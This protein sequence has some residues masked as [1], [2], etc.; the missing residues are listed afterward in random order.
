MEIMKV[1]K[2]HKTK[3]VTIPKESDIE[4]GDYVLL[5]KINEEDLQ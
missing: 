1:R 2:Q 3:I 4:I 5:K